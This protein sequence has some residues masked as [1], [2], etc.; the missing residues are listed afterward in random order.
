[1]SENN[2]NFPEDIYYYCIA[3]HRV[4]EKPITLREKNIQRSLLEKYMD[5]V[6]YGNI[7]KYA[8]FLLK[9]RENILDLLTDEE[10]SKISRYFEEDIET[11]GP[12]YFHRIMPIDGLNGIQRDFP[13]V[14]YQLFSKF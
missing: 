14:L 9:Y 4:F 10:R 5:K 13:R 12:E 2:K 11:Y 7:N 6:S 8:P 3:P 1:M